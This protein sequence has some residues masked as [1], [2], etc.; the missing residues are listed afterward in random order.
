MSEAE[1]NPDFL[2]IV[3]CP[4][5][6]TYLLSVLLNHHFSIALPTETHFIPLFQRFLF[7]WGDLS[8]PKNRKRLLDDV[9]EFL[10]IWT[11]VQSTKRDYEKERHFSL[12]IARHEKDRI[13]ENAESYPDIVCGLF[14]AYAEKHGESC[15]G[16]K[17]AFAEPIPLARLE[18]SVHHLK[19]IHITRDGRDVSL[20]WR[21][22]WCGLRT[23]AGTANAWRRHVESKRKWGEAH[24]DRYLELRYEDL[25][26]QSDAVIDRIAEFLDL[27]A[28]N[29]GV[30][31]TES[32]LAKAL[33]SGQTH[34]LLA[35]NLD[36]GNMYKWKTAMPPAEQRLFAATA[37]AALN[38]CGYETPDELPRRTLGVRLACL[39]AAL[40]ERLSK[41]QLQYTIKDLLPLI[42]F[43]LARLGI[44][45]SRFLNRPRNQDQPCAA[46]D[47]E[48]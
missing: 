37:G 32:E 34:P 27:P 26:A 20:S 40:R 16:D 38:A 36:P 4:R 33:G 25:L 44:R 1:R 46:P 11:P 35:Q 10:D 28:R 15:W 43:L 39:A 31:F 30:S 42:I 8:R 2:F 22:L 6:G 17:S 19:V 41:R 9:F 47:P 13:L 21:K 3:G 24:P 7:L 5:S 18:Q 23:V 14:R 12:L 48:T 29:R 45:P